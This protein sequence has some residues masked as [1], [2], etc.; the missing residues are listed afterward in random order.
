[1]DIYKHKN[2]TLNLSVLSYADIT[3][4][5]VLT[6]HSSLVAELIENH[7]SFVK[8]YLK[9]DAEELFSELEEDESAA[10]KHFLNLDEDIEVRNADAIISVYEYALGED[11]REF[12]FNVESE[13]I[14]WPI[15]DLLHAVHDA[16]GC[17][18]YVAADAERARIVESLEIVR[19]NFPNQMPDFEFLE[20]LET[21]FHQRFKQHLGLE[22]FKYLEEYEY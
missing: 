1:M 16:A 18:I 5:T 9:Y 22:E 4:D 7:C 13:N 19:D 15:H 3:G 14:S 2:I 10:A 17:T 8:F 11:E 21:E 6:L 12:T 20:N